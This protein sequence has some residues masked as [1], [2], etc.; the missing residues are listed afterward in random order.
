MAMEIMIMNRA[1]RSLVQE[2]KVQQIYSA[3]QTGQSGTG[4]QTMNQALFTLVNRR[5]ISKDL[6][7]QKSANPDELQEM[8]I[9]SRARGVNGKGR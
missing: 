8:F 6:A 5:I 7:M 1:I 9:D 2:G 3:M 4:M